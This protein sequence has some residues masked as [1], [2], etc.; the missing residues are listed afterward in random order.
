M[1]GLV[2]DMDVAN[3]PS[4][5]IVAILKSVKCTCPKGKQ[6]NLVE[7]FLVVLSNK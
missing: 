2:P 3:F 7:P 5:R 4:S 6:I 1:Y